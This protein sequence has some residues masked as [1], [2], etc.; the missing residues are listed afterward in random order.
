LN[1]NQ[2]ESLD[3][4]IFA[5]LTELTIIDL[6]NNRLVSLPDE[7]IF[8]SQGKLQILL[9]NNNQFTTLMLGVV[10]PLYSLNEFHLSGNPLE[11]DCQLY[12]TLPWC[13][14]GQVRLTFASDKTETLRLSPREA[15]REGKGCDVHIQSNRTTEI[16]TNST[17]PSSVT[18]NANIYTKFLLKSTTDSN[19]IKEKLL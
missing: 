12:A 13:A 19:H 16:S 15:L 3:Y 4:R 10:Q 9:L 1:Y 11:C 14:Q 18:T 7:R 5:N 2:L 17:L 8:A 6:S